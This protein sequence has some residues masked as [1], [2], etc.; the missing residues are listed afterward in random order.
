MKKHSS[1]RTDKL[2]HRP[3]SWSKKCDFSEYVAIDVI[4]VLPKIGAEGMKIEGYSMLTVE[5]SEHEPI[6]DDNSGKGIAAV[7]RNSPEIDSRHLSPSA[8]QRGSNRIKTKME[9]ILS[10]QRITVSA[11]PAHPKQVLGY[12]GR[13]TKCQTLCLKYYFLSVMGLHNYREIM[14]NS[15][16]F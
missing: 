1:L 14:Y 2:V 8:T 16:H 6:H 13:K 10:Y 3:L 5:D 9:I 12:V 11:P 15:V 4:Y 7:C